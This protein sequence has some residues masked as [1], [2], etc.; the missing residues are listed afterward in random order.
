VR[1][2]LLLL[3]CRSILHTPVIKVN[4]VAN[5]FYYNEE[6]SKSLRAYESDFLF[7][8]LNFFARLSYEPSFKYIGTI[9]DP[10]DTFQ[11]WERKHLFQDT[12]KM[13]KLNELE[14]ENF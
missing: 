6:V 12:K 10:T 9:Y 13:H 5:S 14:F 2:T 8:L 11:I 3:R 7:L 1:L 4:K